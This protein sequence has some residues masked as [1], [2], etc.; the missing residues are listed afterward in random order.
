[1]EVVKRILGSILI[2]FLVIALPIII[3]KSW[4]KHKTPPPSPDN[5]TLALYKSLLFF[6]VQKSGRLPENNGIPWRGNSGLNDGSNLTDVK[7]GLVGGYYECGENTKYHFP[8]AFAM[9]MLSWSVIEYP[10]KYHAI[11]EYDHV[12]NLIKWGTDYLLK[13]FK[14]TATKI[15]KVYSQVGGALNNSNTPN[16]Y[17]CWERP[18]DMDYPRP[19]QTAYAG[20]DL[21]GEMA[22]AFAV[23][24]IVFQDDDAYSKKL[25]K[26]AQT[27]FSFARDGGKRTRHSS[28]NPWIAPYYN[29]TDYY[30]ECMWGATWLYCATGNTTYSSLATN[31]GIQRNARAF[32]MNA[33]T[34]VMSWNNKLPGAMLLLTRF[35][36]FPGYP[37][38]TTL[39]QY[40]NITCLNM[41]SYLKQF[42]VFN[43]THG[44]LIQLN[45][46]GPQPLQYVVNAAFLANLFADYMNA[47]DVPGFNC[48]PYYVSAPTLRNF[49]LS[50]ID[51]I[52]GKNPLDLGYIVGYG[53]KYP[54]RVHHRAASIPKNGVRYSCTGGNRWR[55]ST[56]PNPNTIE[57]AV[58][59]GPDR[60]DHFKDNR[61]LPAYTE[62]TMAGNAGLVAVLVSLSSSGG[63]SVDRN[64]I[65]SGV[66]PLYPQS[67]PPP[68]PWKP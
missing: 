58:V 62:P 38:E 11:N 32:R 29:S 50:Q 61:K 40:H 59:G 22:A 39:M 36:M 43:W 19:V 37:Y 16:D 10:H 46:G 26:G 68:P 21:A 30:D 56:Q 6:N 25:I 49:T 2:A 28:G 5:Y 54:K 63:Y 8:M 64:Y 20:P 27:I 53:S 45:Q 41:C 4:P 48:G 31:P 14:N 42:Q 55:D 13:T 17:T 44:G 35:R 23:A 57:G 34:S 9:T 12:H 67:P 24:A 3:A 33:N 15:D 65:F 1:M 66:P 52:L 51:Y 7:G 60:T 18:E 47:S